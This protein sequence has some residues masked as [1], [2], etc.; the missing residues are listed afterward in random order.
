MMEQN[1]RRLELELSQKDLQ[2]RALNKAIGHL[3]YQ[4]LEEKKRRKRDK[5]RVKKVNIVIVVCLTSIT[6]DDRREEEVWS[7]M[8]V[9]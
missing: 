6:C 7:V 5:S 3:Q 4:M 2:N 9:M 1:Q 8:R